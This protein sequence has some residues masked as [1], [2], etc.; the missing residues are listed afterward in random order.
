[1]VAFPLNG[2]FW[3]GSITVTGAINGKLLTGRAFGELMHRYEIP[4]LS[5]KMDNYPARRCTRPT[6]KYESIGR[7]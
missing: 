5:V 2:D 4:R 3:E 6:R 7:S 1:M